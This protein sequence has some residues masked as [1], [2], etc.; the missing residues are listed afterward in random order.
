M[1][2]LHVH[3][4]NRIYKV[5]GPGPATIVAQL[6][7]HARAMFA[8]CLLSVI[9]FVIVYINTFNVQYGLTVSFF[10]VLIEIGKHL[11]FYD[12]SPRAFLV[13]E[14]Y[15][16]EDEPITTNLPR[17]ESENSVSECADDEGEEETIETSCEGDVAPS[18]TDGAVGEH[19]CEGAEEEGDEAPT[20]EAPATLESPHETNE[21]TESTEKNETQAEPVEKED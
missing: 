18:E 6:Y 13:L 19:P 1:E 17:N 5:Y 20:E 2:G 16:S 9:P 12:E 10:V 14:Y 7:A 4:E 15:P 3:A 21:T 11:T 8:L